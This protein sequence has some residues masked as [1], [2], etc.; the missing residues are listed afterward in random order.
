M[1]MHGK[2]VRGWGPLHSQERSYNYVAV[3]APRFGGVGSRLLVSTVSP[4]I[5]R[6][7]EVLPNSHRTR[8]SEWQ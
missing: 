8:I 1:S 7:G 4:E 3:G 2:W 5:P 6:R